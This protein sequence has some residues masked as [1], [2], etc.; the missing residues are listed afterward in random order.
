MSTPFTYYLYH[1]PTQSHYYGVRWSRSCD[2]SDLWTKYFTSSKT[3][4]LL[5]KQYGVDSFDVEIRKIFSSK[6]KAI[7]WERK[8]LV[9]LNV[10]NRP[11]WLNKNVSGCIVN[12][13]HPL[14]G[15]PCSEEKKRKISAAKKGKKIWSEEQKNQMSISR[16]GVNHWSY[17]KPR[18]ISTRQKI[19]EANKG[20]IPTAYTRQKASEAN[21]GRVL[22]DEHK[23][24]IS[25]SKLGKKRKY[26][27]RSA[28]SPE[29]REKISIS[30]RLR[31][32]KA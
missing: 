28:P 23:E 6:E 29:T 32:Q 17:N 9:R 11:D 12:D 31:N 8:V 14:L 27:T 16:S 7:E 24:K 25:Q 30:L 4:K 5:I 21:K 19:S 2:P 22:T 13:V 10:L 26:F 20:N 15:I 18:P 3:V 1:R